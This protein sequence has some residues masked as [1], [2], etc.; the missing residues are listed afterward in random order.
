[1]RVRYES[2]SP[3]PVQLEL[4]NNQRG[5]VYRERKRD[6]QFV[7]N[8]DLV[9]LPAGDYTLQVSAAGFYHVQALRLQRTATALVTVELIKP[10]DFHVS[11]RA[12][13][14]SAGTK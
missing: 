1:V 5:I 12:L 9:H 10:D 13:F 6:P 7:G 3:G 14:P 11:S 2:N 4:R 8:Y